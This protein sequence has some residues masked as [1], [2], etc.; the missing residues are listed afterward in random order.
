LLSLVSTMSTGL[1]QRGSAFPASSLFTYNRLNF[2]LTLFSPSQITA[3]LVVEPPSAE[4]VELY[5]YEIAKAVQSLSRL[6]YSSPSDLPLLPVLHR[7]ATARLP[8]PQRARRSRASFGSSTRLAFTLSKLTFPPSQVVLRRSYRRPPSLR[9][10][11]CSV[12]C[13]SSNTHQ[14]S[15]HPTFRR[16]DPSS[17][18]TRRPGEGERYCRRQDKPAHCTSCSPGCSQ[19]AWS[20]ASAGEGVG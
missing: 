13:S 7:M 14:S 16:S 17:Y 2:R 1:C 3:K 19:C 18:S 10:F 4:L 12:L 8:R 15:L 20:G 9:H 6:P 11:R 5:L